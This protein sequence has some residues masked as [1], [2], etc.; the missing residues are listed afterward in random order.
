MN[1]LKALAA[2]FFEA[3]F[4]WGQRQAEKP[5]EAKDAQ[6]PDKVKSDWN[7][8]VA[9]RLRHKPDGGDRQPK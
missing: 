5:K 1:W 2:G 4:G 9:D 6:T 7:D 8:Y 3:L